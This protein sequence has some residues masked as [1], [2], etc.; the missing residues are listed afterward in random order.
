MNS[1]YLY[2]AVILE[3]TLAN[4]KSC[5]LQRGCL[6]RL[7]VNGPNVIWPEIYLRLNEPDELQTNGQQPQHYGIFLRPTLKA[8][9]G[10]ILTRSLTWYYISD[11]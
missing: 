10:V 11:K 1:N 4:L 3:A 6:S 2:P 9:F 7:V 5:K 8:F